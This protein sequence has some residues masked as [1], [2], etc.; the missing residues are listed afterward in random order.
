MQIKQMLDERYPE[1]IKIR[2]V[3]ENLNSHNFAS[4]YEIFERPEGQATGIKG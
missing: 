4:F 2:L 3:M 1:S